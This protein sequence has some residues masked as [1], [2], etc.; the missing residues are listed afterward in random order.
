M[1]NAVAE[2]LI[3][4]SYYT[5][6]RSTILSGIIETK[7]PDALRHRIQIGVIKNNHRGFTTEFHM[8]TFYRWRS[9]AQN[10]L[11]GRDRT[12]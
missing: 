10:M 7:S 12:G 4:A 6:R 9:M 1:L 5:A 8:R 3:T 2:I 11:P